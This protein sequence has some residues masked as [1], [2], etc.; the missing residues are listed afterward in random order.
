[1]QR[2]LFATA[3]QNNS[4]IA[5][6]VSAGVNVPV[7]GSQID[8]S[9]PHGTKVAVEV[10]VV[11]NA[12][13]G[14]PTLHV[15]FC[16]S[17]VYNPQ[18]LAKAGHGN[19]QGAKSVGFHNRV[20]PFL[21]DAQEGDAG[22]LRYYGRVYG[23]DGMVIFSPEAV[24]FLPVPQSIVDAWA[25]EGQGG[26]T[27]ALKAVLRHHYA[28]LRADGIGDVDADNVY[29]KTGFSNTLFRLR[30]HSLLVPKLATVKSDARYRAAQV[31]EWMPVGVA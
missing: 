13:D 15:P 28:A 18:P 31:E 22:I 9:N 14:E 23:E 16:S 5:N 19:V 1:M 26:T 11:V 24:A 29:G 20:L 30:G 4:A 12:G 7:L 17:M 21:E 2:S 10:G 6:L 27:T 8:S 3:G 25:Y